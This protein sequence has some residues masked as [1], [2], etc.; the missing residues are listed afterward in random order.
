MAK[1]PTPPA[2]RKGYRARST[3]PKGSGTGVGM[4]EKTPER[5]TPRYTGGRRGKYPKD[6]SGVPKPERTKQGPS[7]DPQKNTMKSN[8][9]PRKIVRMGPKPNLSN[10]FNSPRSSGKPFPSGN[11]KIAN[12]GKSAKAAE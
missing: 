2:P 4:A 6:G 7:G 8:F 3:G 11:A 12:T 1:Y 10:P 9:V 5:T